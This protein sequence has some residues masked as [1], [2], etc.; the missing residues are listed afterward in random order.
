MVTYGDQL[1]THI[2][3]DN[4]RDWLEYVKG[5]NWEPRAE[6]D[7]ES[8]AFAQRLLYTCTDDIGDHYFCPRGAEK[9]D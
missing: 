8:D 1:G 4:K 9:L 7:R 5:P 2:S 6:T 3:T